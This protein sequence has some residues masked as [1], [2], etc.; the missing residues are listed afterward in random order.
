MAAATIDW[1][2]VRRE[3]LTAKQVRKL[4]A[5]QGL[6]GR[7]ST[8]PITVNTFRDWRAHQEFPAPVL[9]IPGRGGTL[10]LWARAD[11]RA[12]LADRR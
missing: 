2:A 12:W 7:P 4:C 5:G 6:R 3:L 1:T 11:V 9:R 10:E 8:A